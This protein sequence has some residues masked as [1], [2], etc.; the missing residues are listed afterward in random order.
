MVGRP[1]GDRVRLAAFGSNIFKRVLPTLTD[2]DVK[3]LV[4]QFDVRAHDPG[5]EDVADA[6]IDGVVKGYPTL[7][8]QAALQAHLRRHRR[9]LTRVVGLYPADGDEGVAALGESVGDKVLELANLV[10]AEREPAV[11]V[12]SFGVYLYLAS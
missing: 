2:A 8:H 6:V 12:F 1:G 11:A 5:H 3:A 4:H 7:L 10:A 9:R